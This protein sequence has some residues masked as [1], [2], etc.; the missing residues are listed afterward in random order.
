[1][2]ML[3]NSVVVDA[4]LFP[5]VDKVTVLECAQFMDAKLRGSYVEGRTLRLDTAFISWNG[6]AIM[7]KV[8]QLMMALVIPHRPGLTLLR[9]YLGSEIQNF[10]HAILD[11]A[12]PGVVT[13]VGPRKLPDVV[14][15]G[16]A[17]IDVVEALKP[18]NFDQLHGTAQGMLGLIAFI[19]YKQYV[20]EAEELVMSL[21]NGWD[22]H[23]VNGH[24]TTV[25]TLE[26]SPDEFGVVSADD[27]LTERAA[28]EEQGAKESMDAESDHAP[29]NS[30]S[31]PA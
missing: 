31:L 26:R 13:L 19:K 17:M 5:K 11:P 18:E 16:L 10:T 30:W 29:D 24:G 12:Q 27:P 7:G 2:Q 3:H 4:R 6:D 15:D 14:P 20:T 22:L 23:M 25:F 1:M 28:L 21:K 8:P 9:Q